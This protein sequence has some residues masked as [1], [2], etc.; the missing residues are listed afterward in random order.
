[1]YLARLRGETTTFTTRHAAGRINHFFGPHKPWGL[2]ARCL[3]Y[4]DFL[5]QPDFA[6][7]GV[8]ELTSA[9]A[10]RCLARFSEKRACLTATQSEASA[11]VCRACKRRRDKSTCDGTVVRCPP[12]TRWWVL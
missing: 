3:R 6:T 2:H 12:T 8:R 9:H 10:K 11:A 4:F 1:M 5:D 7:Q